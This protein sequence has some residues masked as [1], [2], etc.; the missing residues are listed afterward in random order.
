MVTCSKIQKVVLVLSA[1]AAAVCEKCVCCF[2]FVSSTLGASPITAFGMN[3]PGSQRRKVP[4]THEELAERKHHLL[5]RAWMSNFGA[6]LVN[7]DH[8][9]LQTHYII[10]RH[11]AGRY[12]NRT[13]L[14]WYSRIASEISSECKTVGAQI[15][16]VILKT[17]VSETK[18]IWPFSLIAKTPRLPEGPWVSTLHHTHLFYPPKKHFLSSHLNARASLRVLPSLLGSRKRNGSHCFRC[19]GVRHPR[20]GQCHRGCHPNA[21]RHGRRANVSLAFYLTRTIEEGSGFCFE[22]L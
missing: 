4:P 10:G 8:V 11:S 17:T 20:R 7:D 6:L 22:R 12:P 13:A 21:G 1:L 16:H 15:Q 2:C 3:Q 19:C 9:C 18:K 5:V 14:C